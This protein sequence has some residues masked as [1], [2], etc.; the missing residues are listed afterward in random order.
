MFQILQRT[1]DHRVPS[2]CSVKGLEDEPDPMR[3]I[4]GI[5]HVVIPS[6]SRAAPPHVQDKAISL[7]AQDV[8]IAFPVTQQTIQGDDVACRF[9]QGPLPR[10]AER[11]RQAAANLFTRQ[12]G[13][14][15]VLL[16][17]PGNLPGKA[18]L[19]LFRQ[20]INHIGPTAA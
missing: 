19:L 17:P 8:F 6:L 11:I 14:V 7:A 20:A 9:E 4:P 12:A 5:C 10:H 2:A 1:R 16:H 15:E 13:A 18:S 3:I